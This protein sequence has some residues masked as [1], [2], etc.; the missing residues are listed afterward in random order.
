IFID[1]ALRLNKGDK[2]G[3]TGLNGAGKS[4]LMRMLIGEVIPDAGQIRWAASARVGYLDQEATVPGELTIE[5][6]LQTAF[7]EGFADEARAEQL[8]AQ[9]AQT[10]DVGAMER[11]LGKSQRIYERLERTGFYEMPV[12]IARTA[13]GLGLTAMGMDRRLDTL[14]GG[15]RAKVLLAKLLLQQPDVLLLDEPT[16]FL[17][18]GHI[19]YLTGY[20]QQFDGSYIIVS[21]DPVFLDGV[22]NCVCDIAFCTIKRYSGSLAH[23][24]RQK[25]E[26]QQAYLNA[27]AAQQQQIAKLEDYIARNKVRASTAKLAHSREKQLARM[28]KLEKPKL[29]P[30]PYFHFDHAPITAQKLLSVDR[31]AIGYDAPLIR[32]IS[33][34]L[35][36]GEKLA[37]CGFNGV[38]KTTLMRTILGEIPA[39]GGGYHF[40]EAAKIGYFSQ[41]HHWVDP[42]RTPFEEVAAFDSDL[43]RQAIRKYLARCGLKPEHV[44]QPLGTLSGGE[45]AKVKLALLMLHRHTLLLLDEPTNHLDVL[46][47]QALS[48]ALADFEGALIL[49]CHDASFYEGI[50]DRVLNVEKLR[51]VVR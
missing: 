15:Q 45:Q 27:Y 14:S 34:T 32:D 13:E 4:T 28:D 6:Y 11:L 33:F 30:K 43:D 46:A 19:A 41:D 22:T 47:K 3:L 20:L 35:K 7:A 42:G 10:E 21:H 39:W 25:A 51:R 9:L 26:H 44:L 12:R 31:L 1:A 24:E 48:E 5:Q 16:N 2:M 38:G 17:D 49:V 50:T 18:A 23:V 8:N 40:H 37:V 36:A 29:Q